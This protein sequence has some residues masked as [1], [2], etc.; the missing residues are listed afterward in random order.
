MKKRSRQILLGGAIFLLLSLVFFQ[1]SNV[2][3]SEP[4]GGAPLDLRGKVARFSALV[5]QKQADIEREKT[6]LSSLAGSF[7][8]A[9][10]FLEGELK[11][12]EPLRKL[13]ADSKKYLGIY[14]TLSRTMI[15]GDVLTTL[16]QKARDTD[17][18]SPSVRRRL[19]LIGD[20]TLAALV[21]VYDRGPKLRFGSFGDFECAR[22]LIL[23]T[24]TSVFPGIDL[25]TMQTETNEWIRFL[26]DYDLNDAYAKKDGVI[27]RDRDMGEL[28]IAVVEEGEALW[29][30]LVAGRAGTV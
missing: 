1:T 2:L 24:L 23:A 19:D 17:Q 13:A 8:I 6:A 11:K 12:L 14:E 18:P 9:G 28:E 20:Q 27:Q 30:D 16:K 26:N 7:P 5:G 21:V 10:G 22:P 15:S 4:I 29:K 25:A 3:A